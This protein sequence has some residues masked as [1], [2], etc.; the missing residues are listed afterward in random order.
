MERGVESKTIYITGLFRN[1]QQSM[2]YEN[3][4]GSGYKCDPL[5]L[6]VSTCG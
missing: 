4:M 3:Y 1:H 2:D 6:K 5:H